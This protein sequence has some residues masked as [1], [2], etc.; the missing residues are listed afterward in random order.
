MVAFRPRVPKSHTELSA[1]GMFMANAGVWQRTFFGDFA[2]SVGPHVRA[3]LT[4]YPIIGRLSDYVTIGGTT[5]FLGT[6]EN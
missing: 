1:V 2:R 6:F 5:P 3:F 4:D